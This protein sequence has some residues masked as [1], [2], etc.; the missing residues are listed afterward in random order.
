MPL[1]P[2]SESVASAISSQLASWAPSWGGLWAPPLLSPLCWVRVLRPTRPCLCRLPPC[3]H[4][5]PSRRLSGSPWP[6]RVQWPERCAVRGRQQRVGRCVLHWGGR[7]GTEPR[8]SARDPSAPAAEP[9]LLRRPTP[10]VRASVAVSRCQSAPGAPFLFLAVMPSCLEWARAVTPTLTGLS[11]CCVPLSHWLGTRCPA[12]GAESKEANVRPCPLAQS[13][14]AFLR[15]G[16]W[17]HLH[18][19]SNHLL[20]PLSLLFPHL[21]P[22]PVCAHP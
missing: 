12:G 13:C 2:A 19:N 5:C 8:G 4:T 7:W 16:F 9:W 14:F 15:K 11:M 10:R 20:L 17:S 18:L 1:R 21:A 22:Y 6:P 3:L